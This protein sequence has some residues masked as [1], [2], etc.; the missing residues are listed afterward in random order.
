M[1]CEEGIFYSGGGEAV[2]RGCG[3]PFYGGIQ[4]QV[5]RDPGQPGLVGATLPTVG[6]LGLG[7][8]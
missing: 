2:H 5:G 3:F 4:G 7:V 1:R 8:L 6:G